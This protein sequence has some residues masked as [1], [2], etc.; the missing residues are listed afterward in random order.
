MR[1]VR[2]AVLL[3]GLVL[4][5]AITAAGDDTPAPAP[6]P[7]F[8]PPSA[9]ATPPAPGGPA[10]A[11]PA[12]PSAPAPPA[13]AAPVSIA[14][15]ALPGGADAAWPLARTLYADPALRPA[16][17]DE[18]HA[19]VLCGEVPAAGAPAELRDLADTVAALR[20]DDAPS[21]TLLDGIARHF[22]LRALV[23]VGSDAA[24]PTAH[25]FLTETGAF[26]A[27]AYAP[28]DPPAGSAPTWSATVRSLDRLFGPPAV[29]PQPSVRAPL[30][31]TR[32]AP[33]NETPGPHPFYESGWFWGAVGAAALLG[34]AAYIA[35]RDSSPSAI[36]LEVQVPH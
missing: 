6:A 5:H 33:R 7:A 11:A 16:T 15:V 13:A 25:V 9:P 1:R 20:G 3:V 21:R 31:A 34:G 27:A 10:A 19:R 14:V 28:D 26:D 36:H 35:T 12:S 4:A 2:V 32:E 18:T 22:G 30:L 24:H 29:A 23:V 17:V 8:P